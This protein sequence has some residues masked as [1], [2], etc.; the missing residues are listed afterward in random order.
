MRAHPHPRPTNKR[1]KKKEQGR[2]AFE[3]EHYRN[4][5]NH[6]CVY[7]AVV[8]FKSCTQTFFG[9]SATYISSHLPTPIRF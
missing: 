2:L 9:I 8:N 3:T 5:N 7:L 6:M 1:N 4:K